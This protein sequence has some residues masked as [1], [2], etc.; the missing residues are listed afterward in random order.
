MPS[1]ELKFIVNNKAYSD[2]KELE[3]VRDLDYLSGSFEASMA[4]RVIT[5]SPIKVEDQIEIQIDDEPVL[6]GFVYGLS[7][8]MTNTDHSF[9][10]NGGDNSS[11]VEICEIS[12]N[13]TY[14]FESLKKLCESTLADNGINYISV[15]DET[16]TADKDFPKDSEQSGDT[17]QTIFDF[18][19]EYAEKAGKVLTSDGDGALIL[20]SNTGLDRGL[21]LNNTFGNNSNIITSSYTQNFSNRYKT[22]LVKSQNLDLDNGGENVSGKAVDD[23][24]NRDVTKVIIADSV[25]DLE[26]ANKIAQFEINKRRSDSMQY[27]CTVYGFRAENGELWKPNLLVSIIDVNASI[28]AVMLLKRVRYSFTPTGGSTTDLTFVSSDSYSLKTQASHFNKGI[29]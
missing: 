8:S 29:E 15:I 26:T 11:D 6:F 24:I 18:L 14:K 17:G 27:N 5:N 7:A 1:S 9:I 25:S 19:S 13:A 21:V 16:E 22:V 28:N 2:I 23:V 4:N 10:I 20:Y 3:V 12:V